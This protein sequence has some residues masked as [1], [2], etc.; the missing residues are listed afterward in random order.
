MSNQNT[1]DCSMNL[2]EMRVFFFFVSKVILNGES[3]YL[4]SVYYFQIFKKKNE[5]FVIKTNFSEGICKY[6]DTKIRD[7]GYRIRDT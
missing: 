3:N 2:C 4:L 6:N 1:F 7:D 5:N